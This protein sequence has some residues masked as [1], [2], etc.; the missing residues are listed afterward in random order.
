M[1]F[2]ALSVLVV[3]LIFA[4]L[5]RLNYIV[6]D[7]CVT[8]WQVK[9]IV[10][11]GIIRNDREYRAV[12]YYVEQIFT[13]GGFDRPDERALVDKLNALLTRYDVSK[14]PALRPPGGGA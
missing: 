2:A 5:V 14:D 6:I 1:R 7:G 11:R 4:A 3:A 12:L 9:P 13:S 8:W 10:D